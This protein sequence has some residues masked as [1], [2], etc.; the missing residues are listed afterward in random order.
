M[1][2]GSS[3]RG[4]LMWASFLTLIAAGMGFGV[5]TGTL[6]EWAKDFGFTQVELGSIT[7]GGLVGFGVII[8]VGSAVI[9][10]IGYRLVLLAAFLL[11]VVSVVITLMATP[12]YAAMGKDAT[13]QCLFWG[14]F[15][16]AIA[17]GLCEAVINPLIAN[18]YSEKKT[19]YLNI[20]HAGWPGGLILGGIV[21]FAFL[22]EKAAVVRLPWEAVLG[23]YLLPAVWYGI[24]TL[25][26]RFPESAVKKAGIG[27]GRMLAEFASPLLLF[28]FFL[29]ACVGYVELGTDSW[30]TNITES[31]T[32]QGFLLFIYASALMFVLRFY[33]GPIVE[34]VN[35]LGLLCIS[36]VLGTSGLLFLSASTTAVTAWLAVTIYGLGKTFLWPTML[37]I[38]GERFPRG[39]ALTMGAMGGI[40]MLSAGLLG[41]PGIGYKQDLN[42]S[43]H[44]RDGH[45]EAY[46]RYAAAGESGFLF[47]PKVTGLDGQK[48][49]VLLDS[50]G[51]AATLK[52]DIAIFETQGQTVPPSIVSLEEW[53]DTTASAHESEDKSPV[54]EAKIYGGRVAL[55][56]TAAVPA[57][58]FVGYLLLVLYFRS[59]GGYTTVEIDAEGH[60]HA[61]DH[62]PSA[63]EAI[64]T[65]EEG[66]TSGQ[67]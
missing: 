13:Y 42:A 67:A 60:R 1:S 8:L 2:D 4:K 44:L 16:F 52:S 46:Q 33:A 45:P 53:W 15:I 43:N 23:M 58:M 11:H 59:Q 12:V 41:G 37:G 20:L 30:I 32:G 35:P 3:H 39:G 62:H 9:D 19:H 47:F 5:R 10:L 49:G 61:T 18:I 29:H 65:G 66:P 57:T 14:I 36:T 51:S 25:K 38:V 54:E 31:L 63:E 50:K 56:W 22:G 24:I 64:E 40:G 48:V 7:G 27:Y 6:A 55:K 34:R 26:E 17:N 28:L 21:G